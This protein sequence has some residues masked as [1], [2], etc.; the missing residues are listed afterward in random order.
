M[1]GQI[2]TLV[3]VLVGALTSYVSVAMAERARHRRTMAT[4][5]DQR[6]LDTY[7][8]YAECVKE[9][10]DA[11]KLSRLTDEGS[12]A[13]KE[14]MAAMEGGE[15]RR[16]AL[17]EALVLLADPAAIGAAHEVNLALWEMMKQARAHEPP[18]VVGDLHERLNTYH[19]RARDDLG[20]RTDSWRAL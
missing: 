18:P 13:H 7:I 15:R 9:I 6:K 16:S 2:V 8:E 14:F 3:G 11:S 4:R 20:I 1:I 12:E 10:A 17:F 5:W 19:E